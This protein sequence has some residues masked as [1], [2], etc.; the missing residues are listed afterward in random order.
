MIDYE[1]FCKIKNLKEQHGLTSAQI[2]RELSLDSRTVAKWLEEDR[3]KQRKS[4]P[5]KSKLDPFKNDI[6]RLLTAHPYS[7]A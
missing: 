4:T 3:F 7:A 1:L 6:L 5:K 2:S